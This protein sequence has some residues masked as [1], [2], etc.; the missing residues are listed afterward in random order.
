MKHHIPKVDTYD[1]YDFMCGT[2]AF[3]ATVAA[4]DLC[5]PCVKKALEI[6]DLLACAYDELAALNTL[7][8]GPAI[9]RRTA[10][11][12]RIDKVLGNRATVDYADGATP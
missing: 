8:V 2:N 11:L 9:E 1:D 4:R 5:Q 10:L 3:G 6:V 7:S 12:K